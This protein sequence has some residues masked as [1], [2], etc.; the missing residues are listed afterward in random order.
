AG[1]CPAPCSR[2][3]RRMRQRLLECRPSSMSLPLPGCWPRKPKRP[4]PCSARS[5]AGSFSR[6]LGLR[7]RNRYGHVLSFRSW[8]I[9]VIVSAKCQELGEFRPCDHFPEEAA[10]LFKPSGIEY[11]SAEFAPDFFQIVCN[12]LVHRSAVDD[13]AVLP[14]RFVPDPL[15]NLR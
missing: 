13:G 9:D 3:R 2:L 14:A 8:L 1:K 15:P 6:S 10:G 5:L 4:P 12:G 7:K 11:R